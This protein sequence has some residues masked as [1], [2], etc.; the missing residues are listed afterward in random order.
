MP[1]SNKDTIKRNMDKIN[2]ATDSYANKLMAVKFIAENKDKFS[3]DTEALLSAYT[4]LNA[5]ELLAKN[6]DF[7]DFNK[8]LV[9]LL[10]DKK[11]IHAAV[12]E[13]SEALKGLEPGAK[14]SSNATKVKLPE[15][16]KQI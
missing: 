16:Q 3:I 7:E 1:Q 4:S 6:K 9:K 10:E 11:D 8:K 5:A 12:L 14:T 2:R 13:A 15:E